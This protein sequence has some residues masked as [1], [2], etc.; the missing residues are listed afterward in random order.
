[1]ITLTMRRT[2]MAAI[3]LAPVALAA[4][5]GDFVGAESCRACHAAEFASQSET[6]H[7][8]ALARS[9]PPQ[10][11]D[12]AFGAGMQAITFVIR[13]APDSYREEG[14]S[15]YRSLNGEAVTPGQH[16]REGASC[17]APSIRRCVSS[18]VFPATPP[19]R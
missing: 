19:A 12:W 14:L 8:H 16:E 13:V 15:W 9:T 17:S 7:A 10:R 6:S 2:A 11:G 4:G 3:W 5:P 1:M 18:V